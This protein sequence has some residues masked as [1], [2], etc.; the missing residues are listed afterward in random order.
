MIIAVL[1]RLYQ[2]HRTM[3]VCVSGKQKGKQKQAGRK[4][5]QDP[6]DIVQPGRDGGPFREGCEI[7]SY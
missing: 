1:P 5:R 4:E 6:P 3:E 2:A 7:L